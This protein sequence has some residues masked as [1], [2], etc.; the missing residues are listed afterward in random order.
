MFNCLTENWHQ[1]IAVMAII[2]VMSVFVYDF[3]KMSQLK[4]IE[5]VKD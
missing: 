1:V 5:N 2:C 4:K 3:M